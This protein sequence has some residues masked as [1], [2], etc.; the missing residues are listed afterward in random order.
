MAFADNLIDAIQDKHSPL[1]VDIDPIY[2]SLPDDLK[3]STSRTPED[4]EVIDAFYEFISGVIEA[5]APLVPAVKFQ[6]A[7]FEKYRGDG[8]DAYYSLISEA[9]SKGLL[10]IGDVMRGGSCSANSM[11]AS[12]HLDEVDSDEI[13]TPDAI[14]INAISGIE[15]IQPFMQ[16][17]NDLGKG[18]FLSVPTDDVWDVELKNGKSL[19]RHFADELQ[20]RV[21]S[22]RVG[23]S[24]FSSIGL[25]IRNAS[26]ETIVDLRN[27]L[28][29][30]IFLVSESNSAS[31]AALRDDGLG[32]LINS[33][34]RVIYARSNGLDNW[35]EAIARAARVMCDELAACGKA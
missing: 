29:N 34:Q 13:A 1:C 8:V 17:A 6:S 30:S 12:A 25:A 9:K 7:C 18:L 26:A 2:E 31:R 33:G 22:T 16:R 5:V 20:S 35:Q 3:R 21:T 28:P 10:V 24:G 11:F 19:S 32:A 23:R 27:H 15:S 4:A 14:T